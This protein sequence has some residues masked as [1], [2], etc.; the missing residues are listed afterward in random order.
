MF[1]TCTHY[2]YSNVS[3]AP[4]IFLDTGKAHRV[5][6]NFMKWLCDVA[7]PGSKC[8]KNKSIGSTWIGRF[9][10]IMQKQNAITRYSKLNYE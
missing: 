8:Q 4:L 7:I 1:D 5:A 6:A 2:L 9:S 3:I 10:F